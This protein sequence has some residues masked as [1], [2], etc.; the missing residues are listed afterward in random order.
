MDGTRIFSF[1]TLLY[2]D[3]PL[4]H[5]IDLLQLWTFGRS[6]SCILPFRQKGQARTHW[7]RLALWM[8]GP[9]AIAWAS[10]GFTLLVD[11]HSLSRSAYLLSRHCKDVLGGSV[12][13]I[14]G[15]LF[16]SG[17]FVSAFKKEKK[18]GP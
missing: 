5:F 1:L 13:G 18:F 11:Y 14:L 16:V 7:I 2:R 17:E 9:L 15:L 12:M 3:E 10:I 6:H 8:A 4:H